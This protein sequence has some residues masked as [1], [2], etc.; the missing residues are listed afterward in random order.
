MSEELDPVVEIEVH[1]SLQNGKPAIEGGAVVLKLF[2]HESLIG[3]MIELYMEI[4]NKTYGT[5]VTSCWWRY[6][7]SYIYQIYDSLI[8]KGE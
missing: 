8:Y 1:L 2:N 3:D 7:G 6:A 5:T 4:H